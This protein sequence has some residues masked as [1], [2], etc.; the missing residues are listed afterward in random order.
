[1]TKSYYDWCA[2]IID[3]YMRSGPSG[4]NPGGKGNIHITHENIPSY[5]KYCNS[6]S[7]GRESPLIPDNQPVYEALTFALARELGLSTP[8]D[9]LL[10]N[11]DETQLNFTYLPGFKGKA[12][13]MVPFYFSSRLIEGNESKDQASAIGLL[14]RDKVYRDLLNLADVSG[15]RQNVF[16]PEGSQNIIY[17]D[18]GC[19]FVDAQHGRLSQ[20]NSIKKL[21]VEKKS[22]KKSRKRLDKMAIETPSHRLVS[23]GRLVEELPKTELRVHGQGYK[24]LDDLISQREINYIQSVYALHFAR[25]A[26]RYSSD[27]RF[28]R[29]AA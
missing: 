2:M 10:H 17:L 27:P 23:L 9:A 13:D 1:M 28:R 8:E 21:K 5:I 6:T 29:R 25:E 22:V 18:L 26:Q 19:S 11:D 4:S 14:A 7:L 12:F 16:I 15:R 3:V 24:T 20:R